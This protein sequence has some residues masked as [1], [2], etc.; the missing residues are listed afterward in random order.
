[1]LLEA[2]PYDKT[3]TDLDLNFNL[4]N[5]IVSKFTYTYINIYTRTYN[6]AHNFMRLYNYYSITLRSVPDA[7]ITRREYHAYFLD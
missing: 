1:M 2:M 6:K 4:V 3:S 5:H 7:L